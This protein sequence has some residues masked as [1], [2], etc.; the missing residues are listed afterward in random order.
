MKVYIASRYK[1]PES[2][3][4]YLKLTSKNID[5]FLP[6]SID[7]DAKTAEEKEKVYKTCFQEIYSECDV[8]L[9]IYPFRFSVTSEFGAAAILK[10]IG[11][12]KTIIFLNLSD[13]RP[14]DPENEVMMSPAIDRVFTDM[15]SAVEY[16]EKI[17]DGMMVE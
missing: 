15:D 5:A 7:I 8:I 3:E 2:Y 9:F 1:I 12:N 10:F 4:I 16:I 14:S 6:K 17:K 13:E 11:L